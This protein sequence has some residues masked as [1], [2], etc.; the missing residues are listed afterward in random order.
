M[1]AIHIVPSIWTRAS[2]PSYSVP[3]LCRAQVRHGCPTA[4]YVLDGVPEDFPAEVEVHAFPRWPFPQKLGISPP[5]RR[6]LREAW[7]RADLAHN[8]SLWMMPNLYAGDAVEA[9]IPLVLSPHGTMSDWA[10]Q[11]SAWRKR[12]IGR[13]G[14]FR[15][16][17]RVSL[18]R[19]TATDELL[20]IRRRGF[21]QP[22]ALIPNGI[23]IS[24]KV[25]PKGMIPRVVLYAGRIHPKKG[26]EN[27]LKAWKQAE[28]EFPEW[29]LRLV[30]PDN[31]GY[32]VRLKTLAEQLRVA[33]VRFM[34]PRYGAELAAEY[35]RA[36]L[37]VLPTFSENFGLTVAEALA[38]GTPAIVT[39][40]APWQGLEREQCGWWIE[41]GV[42]PLVGALREAMRLAPEI[43]AKMGLQGRAWME[44]DFGWDEIG[45]RMVKTYEWLLGGGE[46]PP[47]VERAA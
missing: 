31:E 36:D 20:D 42:G 33:R 16:L 39:H 22:V 21:R 4:L 12:L 10:W 47:W 9:K 7:K 45:R 8:H 29:E 17:H 46:P 25:N 44:R 3:A 14:Q 6:A 5:M 30:G 40:G 15:V 24:A 18:F 38:N 19:A 27:L 34:G 28:E 37:Y 26:L 1:R 2:G 13:L 43:L 23:E 35:Q 11:R 32:E 41:V